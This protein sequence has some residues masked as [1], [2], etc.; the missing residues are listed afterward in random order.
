M[1]D[2]S[3]RALRIDIDGTLTDI[4]L[5]AQTAAQIRA[6]HDHI[7]C[8]AAD[9]VRP[10][11]KCTVWLDDEGL[12]TQ[13]PNPAVG[14]VCAA[15]GLTTQPYHGTAVLTGG[16]D[17]YGRTLPLPEQIAALAREI[18]T[19]VYGDYIIT[20]LDPAPAHTLT[21]PGRHI[22][23]DPAGARIGAL[24]EF[25]YLLLTAPVDLIDDPPLAEQVR[26]YHHRHPGDHSAPVE[27]LIATPNG[28]RHG[29][30]FLPDTRP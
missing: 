2:N 27:V 1:L 19:A 16:A 30:R 11:D 7:G 18:V 15:F 22:T 28:N 5:P 3:L 6:L 21:V 20:V 14:L 8:R 23:G 29:V 13:P 24:A 25:C 9:C 17:E 12:Y 4:A 26:G 10:T